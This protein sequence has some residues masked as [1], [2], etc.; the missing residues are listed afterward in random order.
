MGT[1][2]PRKPPRT[3]PKG[4]RGLFGFAGGLF[5]S[6]RGR[7]GGRRFAGGALYWAPVWLPSLLFAQ[8]SLGALRPAHRESARL[9]T[10][11]ARMQA[12]VGALLEERG[13]LEDDRA[14]LADPI[15]RERVRR[16][17]GKLGREP[18]T[19]ERAHALEDAAAR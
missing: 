11:E 2:R 7:G 4:P 17:L 14:R 8:L 3:D 1:R 5:G 18:L 15:Y 19:L 9:A 10:E 13:R 6:A 16:S 12:R